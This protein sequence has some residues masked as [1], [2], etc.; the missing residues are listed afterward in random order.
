[1]ARRFYLL[2]FSALMTA[3]T[4]AP[5]TRAATVVPQ[6]YVTFDGTL[7]GTAY[8]LGAGELDNSFTFGGNGSV[9]IT[10]GVADVPGNTDFSSGFLFSGADLVAEEGLGSLQTTNWITEAVVQF[11]VAAASQPDGPAPGDNDNYN[12]FL[13]VQGDTFYRFNGDDR[14]PK[15][16]QFG[17][18]NG[19]TEPNLTTSDPPANQ[20]LHVGLVW[21]AGTNTLEAFVNGASQGAVSS[22]SPFDVSSPNIGY[23]FFSRFLNRSMDGKLDGVAFSTFT[24]AFDAGADFQLEV[25]PEPSTTALAVIG[26]VAAA[27]LRRKK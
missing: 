14:S 17:Y 11:D 7:S 18:W 12:H 8:T 13:D 4:L 6:V 16:T 21:T 23:G 3:A 1:M 20:W 2:V 10:G 5:H 22:A 24:G 27:R 25:V 15:I 26:L 9:S 19:S